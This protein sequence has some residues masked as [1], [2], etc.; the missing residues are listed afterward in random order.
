[1]KKSPRIKLQKWGRIEG[2]LRVGHHLGANEQV[3]IDAPMSRRWMMGRGKGHA[4]HHST[5]L[6]PPMY[7]YNAFHTGTDEQGRFVFT[8]V[9]PGSQ[10]VARLVPMGGGSWTH[11]PLDALD[12]KPGKT[13]VAELGGGGRTVIGKLK[14]ADKAPPDLSDGFVTINSPRSKIM[15][16]VSQLKTEEEREAFYQSDEFEAATKNN[17]NYFSPLTRIFHS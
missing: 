15:D 9:P 13:T 11:S 7:D 6:Q 17:R 8:F 3:V 1:L 2:T 14:F 10:T 5:G 4:V 12:V 16:K